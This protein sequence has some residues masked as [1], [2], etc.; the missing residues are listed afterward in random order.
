MFTMMNYEKKIKITVVGGGSQHWAPTII[1]DIVFKPGMEKVRINLCLLDVHLPRARAIQVLFNARFREW[2][3]RRVNIGV[4][5][6]VGKAFDGADFIIITVSTGRLKT[7]QHDLAIPE[8]YGIYQTV[9]DT[10]G[11]GGWSRALRNIPVFLDFTRQIRKRAPRAFVLN[12]TNPMGALTKVLADELGRQR[13]VG[14]CHGIFSCLHLLRKIFNLKTERDIQLRFGGLNHFFWILDMQIKGEDGYQLLRKKMKGRSFAALV[15]DTYKDSMGFH[16][17]H[18]LASE[19]FEQY[20]FLTYVEDRHTCEF[21]NCYITSKKQMERFKLVRTT[22]AQREA[23]YRHAAERIRLWTLGKKADTSLAPVPS[24][25]TAADII[26]AI[27][28]N[29]GFKDVVNT[30]NVGQISNLPLGAVVETMGYVDAGGITPLTIGPLPG[31]IQSLLWPH[32]NVQIKTVQ[33]GISGNLEEALLALAADPV[34][35]HLTISD[36]KKMGMK[37]LNANRRY[38][39]QFFKN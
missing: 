34:C 39:P 35:A 37:L 33:A 28:C 20:G 21:F 15:K 30:V 38:L 19:L 5:S 14:L 29:Q 7:M 17:G 36:V 12:Y 18:L 23:G 1:R 9:G 8:Q 3:I 2:N 4:T 16:S 6:D 31:P 26:H 11:P 10:V 27:T 22:I 13:V 25:E 24:R 32:A